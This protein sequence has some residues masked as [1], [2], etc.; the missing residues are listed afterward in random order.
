MALVDHVSDVVLGEHWIAIGEGRR[1]ESFDKQPPLAAWGKAGQ[2]AAAGQRPNVRG[3]TASTAK[4]FRDNL[5]RTAI[6]VVA[7]KGIQR[8]RI[9]RGN[10]FQGRFRVNETVESTKASTTIRPDKIHETFLGLELGRGNQY[11][12]VRGL[13]AEAVDK[14]LAAFTNIALEGAVAKGNKRDLKAVKARS[15][16][17]KVYGV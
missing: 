9:K 13:V 12:F 10:Q 3:F 17:G 1:A 4:P 15:K 5:E 6:K 11:L 8:S 2:D 16:G 7:G 14:A